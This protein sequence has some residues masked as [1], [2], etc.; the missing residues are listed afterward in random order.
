MKGIQGITAKTKK[1]L[2]GKQK[3]RRKVSSHLSPSSLSD[4]RFQETK[5]YL[6]GTNGMDGITAKIRR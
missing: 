1:P 3:S 4:K 6:T 2:W 5:G